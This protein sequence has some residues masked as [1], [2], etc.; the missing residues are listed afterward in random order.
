MLDQ[1]QLWRRL[2]GRLQGVRKVRG[3]VEHHTSQDTSESQHQTVST[4]HPE[5]GQHRIHQVHPQLTSSLDTRVSD[6]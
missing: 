4:L 1:S 2:V 3:E 6:K 5:C